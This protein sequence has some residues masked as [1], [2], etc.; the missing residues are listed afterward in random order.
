MFV[1]D[2]NLTLKRH[3]GDGQL[4]DNIKKAKETLSDFS[5]NWIRAGRT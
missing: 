5:R 1:L 3:V 2:M 4:Y